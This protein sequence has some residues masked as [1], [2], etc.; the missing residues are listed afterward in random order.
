[1]TK[2]I[3]TNQFPRPSGIA[4]VTNCA[5]HDQGKANQN[6]EH[7]YGYVSKIVNLGHSLEC[8]LKWKWNHSILVNFNVGERLKIFQRLA[9]LGTLNFGARIYGVGSRGAHKVLKVLPLFS[10]K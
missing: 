6:V 1:M 4:R 8:C 3:Q 9:S 2:G 7:L 5:Y 10:N